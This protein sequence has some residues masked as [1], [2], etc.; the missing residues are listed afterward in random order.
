MALRSMMRTGQP[1]FLCAEILKLQISHYCRLLSIQ[2]NPI[3]ESSRARATEIASH[4][5]RF[6]AFRDKKPGPAPHSSAPRPRRPDSSSGSRGVSSTWLP[7]ACP[8]ASTRA[9]L[10]SARRT[11]ASVGRSTSTPRSSVRTQMVRGT[12][13][14][15]TSPTRRSPSGRDP[16]CPSGSRCAWRGQKC[17]PRTSPR[18]STRGSPRRSAR[19]RFVHARI[20]IFPA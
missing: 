19:G 5:A 14:V 15:W 8:S 2:T 20:F 4:H 13:R 12:A 10:S 9:A 1:G 6:Y 17:P 18:A 11:S 7:W 16:R 3:S